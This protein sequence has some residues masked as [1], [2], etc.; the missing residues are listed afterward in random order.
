MSMDGVPTTSKIRVVNHATAS[1]ATDDLGGIRETM[2][3]I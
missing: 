1:V 3:D 2:A